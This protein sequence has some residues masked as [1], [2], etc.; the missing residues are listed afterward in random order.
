VDGR[1][2]FLPF[3][4][5]PWFR[6]AAVEDIIRFERPTPAHFYWPALDVDLSLSAIENPGRY[7]LKAST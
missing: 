7:P 5:F 4:E 2:L 3:D 1:E 6:K